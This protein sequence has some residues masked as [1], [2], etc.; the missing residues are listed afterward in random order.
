MDALLRQWGLEDELDQARPVGGGTPGKSTVTSRIGAAVVFRVSDPETARALGTA[1]G[2]PSRAQRAV[3]DDNGVAPDAADAVDRAARST[4]SPLPTAIQRQFERSLGADLSAVRVHTAPGSQAA[5]HA[6]GAKAYTVGQDVHFGTGT[7]APDDPFGMHLLAHE[8]A[9]TVQQ[10]G[11]APTR[12]YKLEVS[13]PHDAAEHEADRAADAMVRGVPATIGSIG[14]RTREAKDSTCGCAQGSCSCAA[15]TGNPA[16]PATGRGTIRRAVSDLFG[17][18]DGGSAETGGQDG[19]VQDGPPSSGYFEGPAQAPPWYQHQSNATEIGVVKATI[20]FATDE[21]GMTADDLAAIEEVV[22]RYRRQIESGAFD[23]EIVGFADQRA[24]DVY[25]K[26]LA[27]R[28]ADTVCQELD[29]RLSNGLPADTWCHSEGELPSSN[30]IDDLARNR[31][32]EIRL[33]ER[34]AP[35]PPEPEPE[36]PPPEPPVPQDKCGEERQHCENEAHAN[37]KLQ[38]KVCTKRVGSPYDQTEPDSFFNLG[39]QIQAELA[40][41]RQLKRCADTAATCSD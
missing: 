35:P 30:Q 21:S 38:I 3:R 27:D 12:Q 23:I 2:G 18:W 8:V 31:R 11:G 15:P 19:A 7:Y 10:A 25:N 14:G 22:N 32:V 17:A 26:K 40:R 33:R 41:A 29:A 20:Y 5:A 13:A 36:P 28:R 37:Y 6:L 39:C 34:M 24:D 1:L 4:G 16:A 9:H